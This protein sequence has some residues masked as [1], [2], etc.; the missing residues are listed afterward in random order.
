MTLNRHVKKYGIV[1]LIS[2]FIAEAMRNCRS[3][4]KVYMLKEWIMQLVTEINQDSDIISY[5]TSKMRKK[6][7]CRD[8]LKRKHIS[9]TF[10]D[11][12]LHLYTVLSPLPHVIQDSLLGR[13]SIA[14]GIGLDLYF[15]KALPCRKSHLCPEGK[16]LA[17]EAQWV[18]V[19]EDMMLLGML[20]DKDLLKL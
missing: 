12:F 8:E 15:Q 16:Q 17:H 11:L 19:D 20:E 18:S 1:E 13:N 7:I 10:K 9:L 6:D 5:F 4:R 3:E 14:E 2:C